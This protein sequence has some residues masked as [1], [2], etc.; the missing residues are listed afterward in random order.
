MWPIEWR[1]SKG[2]QI[3]LDVSSLDFPKFHAHRNRAGPWTEQDGVDAATQTLFGGTLGLCV[4]N[5]YAKKPKLSVG[6][7]WFVTCAQGA[8]GLICLLGEFK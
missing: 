1:V 8:M 3:R 6:A 5:R 7:F 4:P 2:S